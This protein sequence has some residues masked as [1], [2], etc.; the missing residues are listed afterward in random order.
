M[1]VLVSPACIILSPMVMLPAAKSPEASRA[2]MAL[3]VLA[4][5]A[6][7]AEL[8]TLPAVAMVSSLVSTMAAEALMS[9]YYSIVPSSIIVLVTLPLSPVVT[10]VPV[11]S[12]SVI[13]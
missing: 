12:G 4:L 2:T 10:T 1:A 7:V 11:S 3:A 5:S 6:V 13:V 9:S 8:L